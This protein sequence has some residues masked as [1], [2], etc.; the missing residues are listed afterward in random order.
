MNPEQFEALEARVEARA[1]KMWTDAGEPAGGPDQFK[2]EARELVAIE[3]VD[4]P[5]I[6][7]KEAARPVVEE[8]SVQGNLGEFPTMRDQGEEETFPDKDRKSVEDSV[9]ARGVGK[10]KSRRD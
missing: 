4:P 2:D 3:E 7:P 9:E 8:A 1:Y 10:P 5:T 6:D